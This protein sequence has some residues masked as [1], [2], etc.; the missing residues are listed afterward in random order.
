M[1][2]INYLCSSFFQRL[3]DGLWP[4]LLVFNGFKAKF[5]KSIE[6][7]MPKKD[8]KHVMDLL[9]L[10]SGSPIYCCVTKKCPM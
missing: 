1:R 9:P 3:C 2:V 4:F 10:L 6:K 7:I 8:N 5:T